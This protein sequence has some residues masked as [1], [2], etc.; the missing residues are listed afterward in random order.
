MDG[1]V[2]TINV[3]A[4]LRNMKVGTS[5]FLSN[6]VNENTLRHTCVSLK[7]ETGGFW[8]VNKCKEGFTVTRTV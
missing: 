6:D 8:T 3:R 4:T 7:T 2:Q 5:V 1:I